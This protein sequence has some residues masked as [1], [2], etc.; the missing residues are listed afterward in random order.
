MPCQESLGAGAAISTDLLQHTSKEPSYGVYSTCFMLL[1]TRLITQELPESTQKIDRMATL[2]SKKLGPEYLSS[3]AGA[4]GAKMTY[5]EGWRVMALANEVFGFNG[6]STEIK[7]LHLD[8]VYLFSPQNALVLTY[9]LFILSL[10]IVQCDLNQE[11][12]RYSAAVTATVRITLADGCYHEDVGCGK[13]D[14]CKSK[15]DALDKV[16]SRNL[17][18]DLF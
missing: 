2:L 1:S 5:I 7:D 16:F 3:R 18:L 12:Q 8:F 6:W 17:L 14:N 4:G 10:V 13:I 15:G 11:S 9:G